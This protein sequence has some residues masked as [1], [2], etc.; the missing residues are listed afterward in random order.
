[1]IRLFR[2]FVPIGALALLFSEILLTTSCFLVVTF[3]ILNVDPQVFLF[4]DSGLQ[5]IAVVVVSILFGLFFEDLYER[6]HVK[7]RVLLLQQLS[8]VLG[9]ALLIQGI[10][11]YV[12]GGFRLPVRV[13]FPAGALTIVALF[14]WRI[15]YSAVV[16][17][18]VGPQRIL[19]V[20]MSP[21]LEEMAGHIKAHPELG[22]ETV[23][24][25]DNS[26]APAAPPA[27]QSR[28]KILGPLSALREIAAAVKPDRIV[29][30]FAE[31]RQ[32]MPIAG[33]LQLRYSGTVIEEASVAY[34]QLCGRVLLKQLRPA[35]IV[36]SG[37][38]RP[39]PEQ[40]IYQTLGNWILALLLSILSAPLLLLAAILLKLSS[41]GPLLHR[42]EC[43]GLGAKPFTLYRLRL[44]GDEGAG[45]N[46]AQEF[47]RRWRLDALPHLWNILR[48][49]MCFV[50]PRAERPEFVAALTEAIPFYRQRCRVKPGITGWAQ[51]NIP[52]D[53]PED[54]LRRLEYDFYYLKN[55]SRGLDTYILIHTFKELLISRTAA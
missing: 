15:V 32:Q 40:L 37:A 29:V 33:L 2:V 46:R 12:S 9:I 23:G 11:G 34:E 20:G 43:A 53:Q 27:S 48:G 19:F 31:R 7:S 3:L 8:L 14:A 42:K 5:R 38:F 54:T 18:V 4:A 1:M 16:L 51:I 45:M 36:F 22:L 10:I 44:P 24:Y 35:Q 30:G 13:M 25:V 39:R 6:I 49:E 41:P 55:F 26:A 21:L 28:S 47:V 17:R 52:P 50:G